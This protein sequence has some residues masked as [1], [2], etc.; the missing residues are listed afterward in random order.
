MDTILEGVDT[1]RPVQGHGVLLLGEDSFGDRGV[2]HLAPEAPP[3]PAMLAVSSKYGAIVAPSQQ[4]APSSNI[5][6]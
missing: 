3:A 4:G 5:A 2:L 6:P 1:L